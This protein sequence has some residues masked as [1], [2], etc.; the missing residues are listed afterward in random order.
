[1]HPETPTL[2]V[3]EGSEETYGAV[4]RAWEEELGVT[5]YGSA[6]DA[7][8]LARFRASPY[9]QAILRYARLPAAS[10]ILEPG[11]GSGKF[12]MAL[13][14]L[15][16]RVIA[17]DYVKAVLVGVRTTE[18]Q[19]A[20]QWTGQ[21]DGYCHANLERLPF[22]DGSFDLVLNEGVIEHWLDDAERLAVLHEMVR[23]TRPGGILAVIVPNGVH[24]LIEIWESRLTGFREAPPMTHYGS[25]R[26]RQELMGAGLDDVCTDG[27]Y[28]WRSWLRVPPWHRLSAAGALLDHL[29]PLPRRLRERWGI[30]IVGLGR[31]GIGAIA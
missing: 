30:N 2:L 27:I 3:Q 15:G 19:L 29:A 4:G 14:S 1:M 8:F 9:V 12:S 11:C 26:L 13:A 17:L 20:G 25:E 5:G 6:G 31:K 18:Q 10:L 7:R 16:H 23:V 22:S 28:P 21:L 24:P